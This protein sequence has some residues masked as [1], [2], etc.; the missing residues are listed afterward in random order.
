MCIQVIHNNLFK[1]VT[2]VNVPVK[3]YLEA[4]MFV[5]L[6]GRHCN[7][8]LLL[9]AKLAFDF[10]FIDNVCLR[11]EPNIQINHLYFHTGPTF[12]PIRKVN[13]Y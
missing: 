13:E 1:K 10:S 11:C 4:R 2:I 7:F 3:G 8:P 6:P 12:L 9:P 5:E